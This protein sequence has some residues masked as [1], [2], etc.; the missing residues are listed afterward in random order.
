[1]SN[2]PSIGFL[3]TGLMGASMVQN[4][5]KKG[6]PVNIIARKKRITIDLL[7]ANGATEL[8]SLRDVAKKSEIVILCLPNSHTVGAVLYTINPFLKP[9]TLIVDCTTNS[10]KAVERFESQATKAGNRYAEAPLTGGRQQADKASLGAIVGCSEKDFNDVRTVLEP[11]CQT[12]ERMGNIG[13]GAKAKLVSNFLALGTATLVVEAM[14]AA[15]DFGVDWKKF[16]NLA[17]LGSGQSMSLDRIAP[18]AIKGE[19][20][21]YAFSV[22]NTLKDLSYMGE[23]FD[24]EEDYGKITQLL[25]DIYRSSSGGG[26]AEEFISKRLDPDKR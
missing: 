6:F 16:Y 14:K 23:I 25:T 3:G 24:D 20:D 5:L 11:C 21:S 15:R 19:F 9:K 8:H 2:F 10:V 1:M 4:L 26:E 7:V 13:S 12:I 22:K 17:S 18:K